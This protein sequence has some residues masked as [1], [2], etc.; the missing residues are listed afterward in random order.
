M[1]ILIT[2]GTG[3]LG[4]HLIRHLLQAEEKDL[5]I[6]DAV[7]NMKAIADVAAHVKVAPGDVMEVTAL[8]D[9][10]NKYKVEGI[11]HLAYLLGTG[12][13]RNPL[14]SI[15]VNCIGTTNVFEAARLTGIKRVVYMS[16][17][18]VFPMRTTLAGSELSED[19]PPA[20]DSVYGACK[21]FNEHIATYYA[22][23]Y[24][25]DPIGIRPTSVFGEGRGHRRGAGADHFMVLPELALLGHPV[26]MPPDEQVSDW[27]YCRDAAEVFLRAYRVKNPPHRIFNMSGAPRKTGEITAYLRE[28]LPQA[29]ISV[30]DKP[31]VMTSLLKTDRLREELGFTPKYTVEE[32][33]LAYLND[34]RKR[35]GM[36]LEPR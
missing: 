21:L 4:R 18:A 23:A 29:K 31:F 12:G 28:L 6:L 10:I 32:G 19:D 7:P 13:I 26:T 8:I 16:S 1:A 36:P 30:S 22:N 33:I 11:I 14:P 25:L 17:V 35:E 15:N 27:M 5:V 20:P 34:V 9:T 3:F 2:G 24:G